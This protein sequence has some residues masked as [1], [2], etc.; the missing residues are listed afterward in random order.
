MSVNNLMEGRRKR[1]RERQHKVSTID[2]Y[3]ES[4]QELS[5]ISCSQ[6]CIQTGSCLGLSF[7]FI[8]N[9]SLAPTSLPLP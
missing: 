1:E 9:T 5:G 6:A 7:V 4:F 2:A 3:L 8:I